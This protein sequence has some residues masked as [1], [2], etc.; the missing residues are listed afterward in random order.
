[1][2]A[3]VTEHTDNGL[4]YGT[5][6][7]YRVKA[8]TDENESGYSTS[9][10]T[11]MS[12]PSPSN[13]TATPI[14]DQSIQLTWSDNCSFESGYRLERS[15]GGSFTQIAEVDADV[16]EHT[17][18]GL[19]YGTDYTYR[20]KAL[21]AL[22]ESGHIETTVAFWQDCD[23]E[24]GGT[25]AEDCTGECNGAAVEDCTGE[26]NGP[27]VEDC[28]GECNGTAVEDCAGECNGAAV[29]DCAGE[30]N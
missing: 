25:A 9:N 16:T 29:E 11:T 3:D 1:V 20:V 22:N 13:L 2:D 12:I 24:W 6:Y 5:D 19:N 10:T 21:T 28:T 30:C 27:A 4:N 8:F 17:D 18:N 7:T 26:C 14:D 23:G 15:D